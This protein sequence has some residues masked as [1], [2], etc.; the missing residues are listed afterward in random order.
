MNPAGAIEQRAQTVGLLD[1]TEW[2]QWSRA[3]AAASYLVLPHNA[4][5]GVRSDI[6]LINED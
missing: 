6:P 3:V 4:H 1:S 5:A 2:D